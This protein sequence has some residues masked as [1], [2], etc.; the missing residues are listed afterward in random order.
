MGGEARCRHQPWVRS[1]PGAG[2]KSLPRNPSGLWVWGAPRLLFV[3]LW[4]CFSAPLGDALALGKPPAPPGRAEPRA[5]LGSRRWPRGRDAR[6][7]AR[8]A[9]ASG[10]G[11]A[12]QGARHSVRCLF[13]RFK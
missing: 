13:G 5:Q 4:D 10:P 2:A 7:S 11:A 8:T 12:K 6:P 9:P 1:G 3:L